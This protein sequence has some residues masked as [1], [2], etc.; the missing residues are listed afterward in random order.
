M[1]P[2]HQGYLSPK[3]GL[4]VFTPEKLFHDPVDEIIVFSF[5][6]FN[7]IV[8]TAKNY[9]YRKEQLVSILDLLYGR[10]KCELEG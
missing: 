7:E 9:G 5:G 1:N 3:S 10:Y 4:Q 8:N 6:Y 2:K